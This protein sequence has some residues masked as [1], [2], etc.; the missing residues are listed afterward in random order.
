MIIS[1]FEFEAEQ[2]GLPIYF[3]AL[4]PVHDPSSAHLALKS[5]MYKA[6]AP[7]LAGLQLYRRTV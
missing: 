6:D 4:L 1:D 7:S 5:E 2:A 3:E